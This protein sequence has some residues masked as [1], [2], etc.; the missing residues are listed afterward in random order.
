MLDFWLC[1]RSWVAP[2]HHGLPVETIPP[3]S[4]RPAGLFR[5]PIRPLRLFNR[6]QDVEIWSRQNLYAGSEAATANQ[7]AGVGL[8]RRRSGSRCAPC[9]ISRPSAWRDRRFPIVPYS[10]A[11]PPKYRCERVT[12]TARRS[13]RRP[14][15]PLPAAIRKARD[16]LTDLFAIARTRPSLQT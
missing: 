5:E 3:V 1:S 2:A 16:F 15:L 13:H 10:C 7:N 8:R 6:S 14:C 4:P 11:N 9:C 12:D